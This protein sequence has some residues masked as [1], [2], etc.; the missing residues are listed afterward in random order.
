MTGTGRK[1]TRRG[2]TFNRKHSSAAFSFLR[3]FTVEKA[4]HSRFGQ[5]DSRR[6]DSLPS[7]KQSRGKSLS[8]DSEGGDLLLSQNV[9]PSR[10]SLGGYLTYVLTEQGVAM[11]PSLPKSER[12]NRCLSNLPD[13]NLDKPAL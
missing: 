4:A 7:D 13:Q 8:D 5:G 3:S 2:H 10:R 11:L 9:I 6:L 1:R 12:T